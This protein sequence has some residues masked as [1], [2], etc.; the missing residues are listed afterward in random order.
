MIKCNGVYLSILASHLMCISESAQKGWIWKKNSRCDMQNHLMFFRKKWHRKVKEW[1]PNGLYCTSFCW[2]HR[3]ELWRN[4]IY[5]FCTDCMYLY[6]S[7]VTDRIVISAWQYH[8]TDVKYWA[9]VTFPISPKT[10]D[11]THLTTPQHTTV[12]RR[13]IIHPIHYCTS[14]SSVFPAS[15]FPPSPIRAFPFSDARQRW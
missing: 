5:F 14:S 15:H 9:Q 4:W 7:D 13:I 1:M 2:K 6:L 12:P 8:W 10:N 11:S 3:V